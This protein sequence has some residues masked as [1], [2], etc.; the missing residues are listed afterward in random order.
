MTIFPEFSDEL[1]DYAPDLDL[2]QDVEVQAPLPYGTMWAFDLETGDLALA[3]SGETRVVTGPETVKEW[4]Y[5]ALKLER[6]ESPLYDDKA[7]TALA[8][9]FGVRESAS[10]NSFIRKE[11]EDA[12]LQHDRVTSV[13]A[14]LV[15][16][17]GH[18]G[19]VYVEYETDDG[20][21]DGLLA[22]S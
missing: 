2:T 11:V 13:D 7:G 20:E 12:L 18:E 5:H 14:S 10:V 17:V 15:F 1:A 19:Y 16:S 4:A 21:A 6:F 9:L 3:D 8:D 22:V